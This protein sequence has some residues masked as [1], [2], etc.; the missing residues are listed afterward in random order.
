MS[1]KA[2]SVLFTLGLSTVLV[3]APR[4]SHAEKTISLTDISH[5]HALS[6]DRRD[7]KKLYLAT[8]KGLFLASSDGKAEPVSKG[9]EDFTSFTSHP[10]DPSVFIATETSINGNK[11]GVVWSDNGGKSWTALAGSDQGKNDFH[12]LAISPS[13]P[14]VLYGVNETLRVSRN[15]GRTWQ[16][17]GPPPAEIFDIAVS[18]DDTDTLFAATRKALY[19][20]RDGGK[21]WDYAYMLL[22]PATMVTVTPKG[23]LYAFIYGVGLV[24]ADE[25]N[26]NWTIISKDF[27]DRYL[28]DLAVDPTDPDRLYAAVDT[29]SV[30]TSK[31]G[32]KTWTTFENHEKTTL[33]A[34]TRGQQLFEENCQACHGARGVG[35]RPKDMYAEDEYG[36]VAPPLDNSAHGW[37]HSDL[38]I[39]ETI[40]NGSERNKRMIAWKQKLSRED[41]ENILAY[42]KSIW[43]FRSKACQGARHMQCM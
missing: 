26:L 35:E 6:I 1:N 10:G 12:S 42:I 2:I 24:M 31:D 15:A 28:L 20:S 38:G 36:F 34:V 22:K 39:V 5:I 8:H 32:G 40:L 33:A 43:T 13:D 19:I 11:L 14:S 4:P 21:S 30:M 17:A 25:L 23:K 9:G 3:A 41:A 29:G 16:D 27:Q 37:H 7:P 18:N